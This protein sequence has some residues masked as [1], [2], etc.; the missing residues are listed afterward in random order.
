MI[1]L[2]QFTMHIDTCPMCGGEINMER[3]KNR[4]VGEPDINKI[5]PATVFVYVCTDDTGTN[6]TCGE[7]RISR[8]NQESLEDDWKCEY[9]PIV[10][11]LF[12]P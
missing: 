10:K 11:D 1:K 12:K 5:P 2:R 8:V 3:W 9:V 6:Q 4:Y 7:F